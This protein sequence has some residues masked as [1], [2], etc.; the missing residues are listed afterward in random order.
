MPKMPS[1]WSEIQGI[2][3]RFKTLMTGFWISREV[4]LFDAK[5]DRKRITHLEMMH[6]IGNSERICI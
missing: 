1:A 2:S 4:F 5:V 3:T 6:M